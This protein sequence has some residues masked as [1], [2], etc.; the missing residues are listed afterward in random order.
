MSKKAMVAIDCSGSVDNTDLSPDTLS[1]IAE[2]TEGKDTETFG[3][4]VEILEDFKNFG[5][6]GTNFECVVDRFIESGY[7]ELIIVSDGFGELSCF[8]PAVKQNL[9][10]IVPKDY[11]SL[12][13]ECGNVIEMEVFQVGMRRNNNGI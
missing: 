12:V 6:G 11:K 9:T 13:T 8:T 2:L 4:D 10:W 7:D 1:K 5:R 3:F